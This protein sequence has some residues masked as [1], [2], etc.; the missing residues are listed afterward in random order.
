MKGFKQMNSLDN[1]VISQL[2]D[3]NNYIKIKSPERIDDEIL[4]SILNEFKKKESNVN[5]STSFLCIDNSFSGHGLCLS[6]YN[7]PLSNDYEKLKSLANEINKKFKKINAS[8]SLKSS[9]GFLFV[10]TAS[11]IA[12][13]EISDNYDMLLYADDEPGDD[14]EINAIIEREKKEKEEIERMIRYI[15]VDM[16][17]AVLEASLYIDERVHEL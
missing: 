3:E 15:L 17:L 2:S 8:Y 11:F 12:Y 7:A 4:S 5:E 16:K 6:I 13:S 14:Q 1:Y 10:L 9:V